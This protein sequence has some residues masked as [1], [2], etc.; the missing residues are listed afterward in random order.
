MQGGIVTN[1]SRE[2]HPVGSRVGGAVPAEEGRRLTDAK[3]DRRRNLQPHPTARSCIGGQLVDPV[4]EPR[5][6]LGRRGARRHDAGLR[7]R[8]VGMER[9][10]GNHEGPRSLTEGDLARVD[11]AS[12]P[13][14]DDGDVDRRTR[15]SPLHEVGVERVGR[16]AVH[17]RAR[18]QQRLTEELTAEDPRE[19]RRLVRSAEAIAPRRLEA[20]C[21]EE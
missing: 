13:H 9:H 14:P 2:A 4:L 6:R 8:R 19:A 7:L 11:R 18:G 5:E 16:L 12:V 1:G 20:E 21:V 3:V 10:H 17:G 15:V